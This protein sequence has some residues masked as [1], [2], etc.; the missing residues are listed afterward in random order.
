MRLLTAIILVAAGAAL[1]LPGFPAATPQE[2][3]QSPKLS[4]EVPST[5]PVTKPSEH[6]FV[7]PAPYPSVG[8][9]WIG[10]EKLWTDITADGTW[11]GLPHYTPEDTRFR[12]KLFWWHEGYDW[13]TENPPEL[14]VRGIRLDAPA[15][16]I[17]MDEHANAGWTND[18]D[19]AFIVVGI[20]IP[21][22]GCWKVTGQ[23]KGGELSYVV[24]VSDSR[25]SVDSSECSSNDLLAVLKPDDPA[26]A[27]AMNLA[28][29]LQIHGF[30]I[31]C[32]LQ[33][34][35]IHVFEGQKSA[36]LFRTDQGDFEAL[37]LPNTETF[38]STESIEWREN[39]RFRYSFRGRPSPTSLQPLDSAYQMFFEKH[40]NQF[41]MTSKSQLAASIAKAVS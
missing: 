5:C 35:M 19:H 41:F 24:W 32:V 16:P 20:F 34:K 31:K 7:P 10:S 38:D 12:Q 9:F 27:D 22:V 28:R 13:R 30:I 29:T 36:A 40:R 3:R 39:D 2:H 14:T 17:D 1:T 25:Q 8:A 23:Y 18:R 37:F 33:S 11:S 4:G 6:P 21:T 15:P 26:Y